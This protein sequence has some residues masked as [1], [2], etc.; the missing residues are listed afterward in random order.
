[1]IV[2]GRNRGNTK[3]PSP[4]RRNRMLRALNHC[5]DIIVRASKRL[6]SSLLPFEELN[7]DINHL[8][9]N[10]EYNNRFS[11]NFSCHHAPKQ[12]DLNTNLLDEVILTEVVL[13]P[14]EKPKSVGPHKFILKK[15]WQQEE[16]TLKNKKFRSTN[17]SL[18]GIHV[19]PDND[20][21][22][23]PQQRLLFTNEDKRNY[24]RIN[25]NTYIPIV[26]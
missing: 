13:R 21:D 1:M 7:I 20:D 3:P 25:N 8:S 18:F 17:R 12:V 15:K 9:M 11:A 19:D 2:K 5:Q 26:A 16:I 4:R 23:V 6:K 10:S 14:T 22:K 24:P